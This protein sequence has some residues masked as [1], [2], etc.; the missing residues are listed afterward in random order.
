MHNSKFISIPKTDDVFAIDEP[1]AIDLIEGKRISDANKL[2]KTFPQDEEI[3]ILN[4]RW[5]PYIAKGKG[6][7]K[8][9]KT[10]KLED[11]TY[12]MVI[13]IIAAEEKTSVKKAPTAAKKAAPKKVA[14]KKKVSK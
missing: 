10:Q 9:A 6:N 7:Y 4:G 2:L 5:G 3:K 1:R 11:L 13:D 14:A 8:L 12:E